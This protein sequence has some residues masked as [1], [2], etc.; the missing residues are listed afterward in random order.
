MILGLA[1]GLGRRLA[2]DF[3]FGAF[4]EKFEEQFGRRALKALLILVSLAVAVF[5]CQLI[6]QIALGPLTILMANALATGTIVE[7]LVNIFWLGVALAAGIGAASQMSASFASWRDYKRGQ[8]LL[9]RTVELEAELSEKVPMV[10]N[11]TE[12]ASAA[13]TAARQIL[14]EAKAVSAEA[15]AL[16]VRVKGEASQQGPA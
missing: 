12:E 4:L 13:L 7:A 11:L 14:E 9:R 16:A 6:W 8:V 10:E 3:G 5:C 1:E 2:V 15:E